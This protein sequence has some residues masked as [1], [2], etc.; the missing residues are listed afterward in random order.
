MVLQIAGLDRETKNLTAKMGQLASSQNPHVRF[1]PSGLNLT[2][3]IFQ[4]A[5][6]ELRMQLQQRAAELHKL[7]PSQQKPAE[8]AGAERLGGIEEKIL[9]M[10]TGGMEATTEN[11]AR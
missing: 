6:K 9:L 4:T 3:R 5:N 10:L 11:V 8:E 1:C 2:G 7:K